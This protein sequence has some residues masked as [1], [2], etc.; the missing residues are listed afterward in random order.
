MDGSARNNELPDI[1][2]K[3]LSKDR[4][5]LQKKLHDEL[6][7]FGDEVA[8][9]KILEILK[10]PNVNTKEI[11]EKIKEMKN[12]MGETG[13]ATG[14]ILDQIH[15]SVVLRGGEIPDEGTQEFKAFTKLPEGMEKFQGLSDKVTSTIKS[16]SA[17]LS[18]FGAGTLKFLESIFGSNSWLGK[19]FGILK[20][21]KEAQAIYVQKTLKENEKG[22][23]PGT[24]V[25]SLVT[26]LQNQV[27]QCQKIKGTGYDFVDHFK[28]ILADEKI[29]DTRS[30]SRED[31]VTAHKTLIAQYEQDKAKEKKPETLVAAA[32][33]TPA[34][35]T[36]APASTPAA[37][38]PAPKV[39]TA[40]GETGAKTADK[41][42]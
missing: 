31:I 21:S 30:L 42:Q 28:A 4:A 8:E 16:I 15:A 19:L 2:S 27:V 26:V 10:A 37:S 5:V 22:L 38:A 35:Q 25:K 40:T 9:K 13:K 1:D 41:N 14:Q 39:E 20:N 6:N 7:F 24:D 17:Q 12:Q 11:W 3:A 18:L 33:V 34:A 23:A 29:S 36:A 32:T